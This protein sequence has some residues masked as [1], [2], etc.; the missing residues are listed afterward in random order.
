MLQY[1]IYKLKYMYGEYYSDNFVFDSCVTNIT[2]LFEL[3]CF[4]LKFCPDTS[5]WAHEM[6]KQKEKIPGW[7][8]DGQH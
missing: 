8:Q 6:V 7:R 3:M 5:Y 4:H 2:E 1:W